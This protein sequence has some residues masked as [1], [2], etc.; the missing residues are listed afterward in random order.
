L[1]E[2]TSRFAT[3]RLDGEAIRHPPGAPILGYRTLPIA[4]S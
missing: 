1:A 2:L 3:V 4:W